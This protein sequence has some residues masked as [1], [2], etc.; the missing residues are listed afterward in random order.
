MSELEDTISQLE[1]ELS[2]RRDEAAEAI[3]LW[4]SHCATLEARAEELENEL[5]ASAKEN[6][7]VKHSM[8]RSLVSLSWIM[9][10]A[11]CPRF[12]FSC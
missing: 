5:Q 7:D 12:H 1:Q 6:E 3:A 9:V 2:E 4:E 8:E 10:S 11:A